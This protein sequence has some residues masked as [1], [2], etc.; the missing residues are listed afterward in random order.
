MDLRH[1]TL[2]VSEIVREEDGSIEHV[3]A[4]S[5]DLHL[6]C[7]TLVLENGVEYPFVERSTQYKDDDKVQYSIVFED[8]SI[9]LEPGTVLT[10]G[11][12]E[13]RQ[14][15]PNSKIIRLDYY[16]QTAIPQF[17]KN[18]E[19]YL[20]VVGGVEVSASA[21]GAVTLTIPQTAKQKNARRA[22]TK[23]DPQ[24]INKL[25]EDMIRC[26]SEDDCYQEQWY[27]DTG[28]SF[29]FYF[30]DGT[31]LKYDAVFNYGE[32]NTDDIIY[33]FLKCFDEQKAFR[34]ETLPHEKDKE[35]LFFKE[36]KEEKKE[37]LDEKL[38][39]AVNDYNAAHTE[40]SD[41]GTKLFTQ[42]ERA[43]D[44]LENVE[45]LVNS[46]ANHPKDFDADM[47]EVQVSKKKF[48]DASEFAKEELDAAKKSAAGVGA[49]VAGGMAVASLAPSAAMWIATTFGTASTGT[50][51]SALSGAA[52]ESAALAWLGGGA[53]AAG[54]GGTAAGTAFLALSGPV[55]W[56]IAGATLLAS[57]ALFANKKMKLNREKKEEIEAVLKNT[58]QV[59][60]Y[61]AKIKDILNKTNEIREGL[62]KQYTFCM[63]F[64]GD[65]FLEISE[66][67][68]LALGTLVN[69]AKA[70]AVTL[71]EGVGEDTDGSN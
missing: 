9:E 16:S 25:F 49:G 3:M 66:D 20:E 58:E 34:I 26:V 51:I 43:V 18:D 55:G 56:G 33:E 68:Q 24:V 14:D 40:I 54:G 28:R 2:T 11:R 46:I 10:L 17:G 31:E 37:D 8:Q 45:T 13:W 61:S 71:E 36:D 5:D 60:E 30:E 42:R 23:M 62:N 4:V 52:A 57:I 19:F 32:V 1:A 41:Y 6:N 7:K 35:K 21:T 67:G 39:A 44:L 38:K 65:N 64:F 48:K 27:D 29:T 53:V 15:I 69:N 59:K 47:G 70:L 22:Y 63:P 50:A 12:Q